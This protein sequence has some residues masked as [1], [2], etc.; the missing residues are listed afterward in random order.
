MAG[1]PK[2]RQRLQLAEAQVENLAQEHIDRLQR[3]HTNLVKRGIDPKEVDAEAPGAAVMLTDYS[4]DLP[5][6]IVRLAGSGQPLEVIRDVLGFSEAQQRDWANS[7]VDFAG[8]IS[9]A[10]AREEAFWYRQLGTAAAS[11][12]RTS[13]TSI[14]ALITK[15]FISEQALGDASDLVHVHI[16]KPLE[17]RVAS[18]D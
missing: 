11:G 18:D 6:A 3:I 4:P 14:Q 2:T 15:K 16:G 12:D 9:R 10:R 17:K 13:L 1:R 5:L 7:Y 8:A